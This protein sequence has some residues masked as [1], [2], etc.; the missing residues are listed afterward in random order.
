MLLPLTLLVVWFAALFA[1]VLVPLL[2][3]V[4]VVGVFSQFYNGRRFPRFSLAMLLYVVTAVAIQLWAES[5]SS[6]RFSWLMI[7]LLI[8]GGFVL[9][10]Q[11]RK[12]RR[13]MS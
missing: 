9:H 2:V 5:I 7:W 13:Q 12:T 11:R 8:C 6:P 1:I 10:L 3:C 4:G